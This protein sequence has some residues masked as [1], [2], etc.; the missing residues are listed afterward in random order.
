M[1]KTSYIAVIAI[2]ASIVA[3]IA[4]V[5]ESDAVGEDLSGEYGD[6]TVIEIAPGFEWRYTPTF[7][8][9]LT[10]YV[11][12][13]LEVN[14][15]DVGYVDGKMVIVSIPAE[16]VPGT[17]YNVVIKASMTEPVSQTAY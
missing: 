3:I 5:P 7:P 14:D 1:S 12:V 11:T 6:A 2:L 4:L 13:S 15:S 16:A 9:D 10:E 17:T 8:E